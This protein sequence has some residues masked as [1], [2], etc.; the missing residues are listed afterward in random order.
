MPSSDDI[1]IEVLIRRPP[2]ADGR[3]ILYWMNAT[4]RLS[5]NFAL[6]RALSWARKLDRPLLV[7]E[8]L[9]CDHPHANLRHHAFALDGMADN[10]R[11]MADHPATYYPFVE[12]QPGQNIE[13]IAAL[14]KHACVVLCDLRPLRESLGETEQ[15]AGRLSGRLERVD[16]NGILP[17]L[18]ADREFTTAYSL[19]RFLQRHLLPHLLNMPL[20][21]PL[22]EHTLPPCPAV[23]SAIRKRWPAADRQLLTEDRSRLHNLPIGQNTP[24][25]PTKGGSEAARKA[26]DLFLREHL[27]LYVA[28][29]NQPQRDVTSG[30]S[31]YL[32]WGHISSHEI[33]QRLL[34]REGWHPSDLGLE[35]RGQRSGWWGV[36]ADAEAFL[37]QLV[38]WRELGH[39]FCFKRHDYDRME[40]LPAWAQ[41][42]L[43]DHMQDPRPYLY[44]LEEFQAGR[45]HDPL[46]NAAQMQLVREGRLHNYLRMLWGKK[47]L[48][49][50]PTPELAL[51]T[52]IE[53]NDRFAL[54]GCD[55]NSY[56]GIGWVLGRFDRAWGPQRPVFG[57][58]R[59]MSSRNTARKVAVDKYIARYTPCS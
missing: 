33:V 7:V 1:R 11:Y 24:A 27:D 2:R 17:L 37:D 15:L 9:P 19:R 41:T 30:L 14:A 44:S 49:W 47:I 57:K 26:L 18:A 58:I 31:P 48:Q 43:Q 23:P 16:S 22:A 50:S 59:Y 32:R 4:R 42:T 20:P 54:D 8:T 5:W 12:D 3:Y 55:P 53:L 6:Q 36:G 39:L 46:W 21:E 13:L 51:A 52:M 35:T 40:S 56:S 25:V 45:T 38:T 10:A 29:R 34:D 28:H